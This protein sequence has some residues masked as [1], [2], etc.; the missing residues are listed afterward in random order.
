[1]HEHLSTSS[2]QYAYSERM[3]GRKNQHKNNFIMPYIRRIMREEKHRR[4][5]YVYLLASL[6]SIAVAFLVSHI[7]TFSLRNIFFPPHRLEC[8]S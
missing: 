2:V 7:K 5:Q 6:L 3:K 4:M 1:M 8:A